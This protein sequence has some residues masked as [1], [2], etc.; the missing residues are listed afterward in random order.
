MKYVLQ[1]RFDGARAAALDELPPHERNE[2]FAEYA[3]IRHAAGVLDGN[4]LQP[5][6]TAV[7]VQVR[8][9]RTERADGQVTGAIDGY[10]LLDVPDLDA[11]VA[12]AARIPA[13]R[14]GGT[15]EVRA[16]FE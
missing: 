8:D 3:G 10:Y 6:S 11:A 5:P 15:V 4:Q 2:I 1:V 13:P 7:T 14:M 12:F 9:G 16:A